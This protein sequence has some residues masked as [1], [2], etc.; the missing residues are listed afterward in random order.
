MQIWR[1]Q[2][3]NKMSASVSRDVRI[4][5]M[6]FHSGSVY[7]RLVVTINQN[8]IHFLLG[9]ASSSASSFPIRVFAPSISLVDEMEVWRAVKDL[10]GLLANVNSVWLVATD[11]FT[12]ET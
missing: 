11:L 7:F 4:A 10:A 8:H 5:S 2:K 12:R 3:Q 1:V 6:L 9:I